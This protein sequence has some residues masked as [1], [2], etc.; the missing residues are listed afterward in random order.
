MYSVIIRP[1]LFLF[2]PEGV[3]H[4]TASFLKLFMRIPFLYGVVR[5]FYLIEHP[6]L[7]REF[8][9]LNFAH[10]VG[11]AAGFDKDASFFNEFSAFGFSFI[12]VGTVTPLPQPGNPKP[13]LFRLPAN[14]ALIN[15]MGFNNEGV[16]VAAERLKNR[17]ASIVVGGNIGKNTTTPNEEAPSDYL[18][19]LSAL[20]DHVDYFVV[21][22]SCPNVKDLRKLQDTDSLGKILDVV[23]RERDK[24]TVRKPLLL[25]ISP[26]LTDAQIDEALSLIEK[27]G[28]DGVVATNT[29][30][31][32]DGLSLS[33]EEIALL[34]SGG[35]SGQPLKNRSTEVIRYICK[36]TNGKL[37][38]MGV[39]GIMSVEDAVEKLE[40]GA[41]LIQLY[42]GFIYEGPGL[43]KKICKRLCKA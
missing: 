18:K 39:G 8:C 32:R 36:K 33:R 34:G 20:Y 40:A 7:K 43:V 14:K 4:F 23:T 25:K 17:S 13:R 5:R 37:P 3:H 38:I 35:L 12:E 30:T 16:W 42:T 29:T 28:I 9:G 15:R 22:V 1:F 11:F 6:S 21:N 2:S 41:S 27:F 19:C 24:Q 31:S 26:D 10:P